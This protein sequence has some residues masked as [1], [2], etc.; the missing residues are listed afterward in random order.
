MAP[1]TFPS[2]PDN[3]FDFHALGTVPQEGEPWH[4]YCSYCGKTCG[5]TDR[6][7]ALTPE[8]EAEDPED[9]GMWGKCC[10]SFLSTRLGRRDNPVRNVPSWRAARAR[11]QAARSSG[12]NSADR[13]GASLVYPLNWKLHSPMLHPRYAFAPPGSLRQHLRFN[14]ECRMLVEEDFYRHQCTGYGNTSVPKKS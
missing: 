4:Y 5:P 7:V 3:A 11:F 14:R 1:H 12:S 10:G 9:R 13:G 8:L 2:G 6:M